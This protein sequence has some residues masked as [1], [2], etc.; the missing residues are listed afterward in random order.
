[1]TVYCHECGSRNLRLSR[2]QPKDVG[3]FL[4]LRYPV[5]CRH[6]RKRFSISIFSVAMIR[7]EADARRHREEYE[8]RKSLTAIP[9]EQTSNDQPDGSNLTDQS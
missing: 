7:R 6:C 1:M 5:R 3:Y 8:E 4:V 9:D 2:L